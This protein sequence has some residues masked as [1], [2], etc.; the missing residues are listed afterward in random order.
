MTT[1][2]Y[3]IDADAAERRGEWGYA[4]DLWQQAIDNYPA[5][6]RNTAI[7]RRDIARFEARQDAARAM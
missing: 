3:R 7:G 2:Q 5:R 1:A 4:I 6:L